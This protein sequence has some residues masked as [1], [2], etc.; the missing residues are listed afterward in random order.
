MINYRRCGQCGRTY[1]K[2]QWMK[3]SNW[4]PHC[5]KFVC[6]D[7]VSI[8]RICPAC[9]NK[10]N[11]RASFFRFMST[12]MFIF[13]MLISLAIYYSQGVA[14]IQIKISGYRHIKQ[15]FNVLARLY[16][17]DTYASKN[18]IPNGH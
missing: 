14:R 10:V 8:A 18:E 16:P 11:K 17:F 6:Y 13:L 5:N 12:S 3:Q 1:T 7:C 9:G 15:K 2:S 4:C